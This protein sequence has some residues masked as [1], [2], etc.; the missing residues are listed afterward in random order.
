MQAQSTPHIEQIPC[1]P[2][3]R[4]ARPADSGKG[5]IL[6]RVDAQG[7]GR[8][9]RC[10]LERQG[11]AVESVSR[12]DAEAVARHAPDAIL[13][14]SLSH[15]APE[16]LAHLPQDRPV[17]VASVGEAPPALV[18]TVAEQRGYQ[19]L[20]SRYGPCLHQVLRALSS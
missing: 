13:Y 20:R 17:I 16:A 2:R 12:L 10:D 7:W 14:F 5:K 4:P 18:E 8:A 3:P 9:T 19:V 11:Y 1:Q 6:L 15:E